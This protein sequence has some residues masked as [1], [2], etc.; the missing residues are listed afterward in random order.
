MEKR[1]GAPALIAAVL[2]I[3]IAV[4]PGDHADAFFTV[5]ARFVKIV[6]K[7]GE[8]EVARPVAEVGAHIPT[9][10]TE[11]SFPAH[12]RTEEILPNADIFEI[13]AVP[14]EEVGAAV[15]MFCSLVTSVQAVSQPVAGLFWLRAIGKAQINI[16]KS[17]AGGIHTKTFVCTGEHTLLVTIPLTVCTIFHHLVAPVW[18]IWV[19][20]T[21]MFTRNTKLRHIRTRDI[22]RFTTVVTLFL[23]REVSAV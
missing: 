10:G 20:V 19:A 21:Q 3:V 4:A 6:L 22:A 7:P 16:V 9:V 8:P 13:T 23:V 2:A 11:V 18:T 17:C 15:A 12:G 5:K 1:E 14:H